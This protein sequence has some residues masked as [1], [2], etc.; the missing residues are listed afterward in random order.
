MRPSDYWL[1]IAYKPECE[2][3][4]IGALI[5]AAQVLGYTPRDMMPLAPM[6]GAEP[7]P[8]PQEFAEWTYL[9]LCLQYN[10]LWDRWDCHA[11]ARFRDDN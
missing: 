7:R 9:R 6:V 4:A 2:L 3:K 11:D 8:I 10:I 5:A 1:R